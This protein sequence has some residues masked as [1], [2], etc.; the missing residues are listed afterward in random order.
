MQNFTIQHI[1]TP[2]VTKGYIDGDRDPALFQEVL[3]RK[4]EIQEAL[5]P[6]SATLSVN[7][8]YRGAMVV[9]MPESQLDDIAETC[10]A[11]P[12]T[13]AIQQRRRSY[14]E[15]CALIFFR[16]CLSQEIDTGGEENWIDH[17]EVSSAINMAFSRGLGR[18]EHS[19]KG[20]IETIL[21]NLANE[22][23]IMKRSDKGNIQWR[24]TKWLY[25][26][27]SQDAI[28]EFDRLCADVIEEHNPDTQAIQQ[29]EEKSVAA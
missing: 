27:L 1:I 11:A 6:L 25:I 10:D 8:T 14:R 16:R 2:L 15:S 17:S 28:A 20:R 4:T 19:Q 7:T 22:N 29:A 5:A 12:I 18:D 9:A 26:A 13:P 24:G 23:L 21:A 3:K